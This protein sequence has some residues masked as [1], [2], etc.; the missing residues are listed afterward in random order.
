MSNENK[1]NIINYKQT[2]KSYFPI[3]CK[4]LCQWIMIIKVIFFL[5]TNLFFFLNIQI[6]SS[7]L[8]LKLY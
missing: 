8:I 7:I 6:N 1:E 3:G 5:K 4:I 2:K